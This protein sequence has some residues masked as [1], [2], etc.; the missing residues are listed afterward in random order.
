MTAEA[1]EFAG[2]TTAQA[3]AAVL[4]R[5]AGEGLFVKAEDYNHGVGTCYRCGTTIEPLL[6]LQW[7]MDMK[8]L[9][10]PAI[11]AVED[12]RVRFVPGRWGEVYLDWMRS[13]RPWCISRQLWWGH[14]IPAYLCED[15][16]RVMVA[17]TAPAPCDE[18]GGGV[19]QEEDVLDTWFSSALWPFAT[20]GWPE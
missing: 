17:A 2:L 4:D 18:C 10:A 11:A 16:G 6:S 15:C 7:F 5:L 3:R 1:G 14:R 19:R 8:R 20:L 13:I 12:G 9:A